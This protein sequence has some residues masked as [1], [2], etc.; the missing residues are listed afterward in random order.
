M[1]PYI[2]FE[3]N[4]VLRHHSRTFSSPPASSFRPPYVK[5]SDETNSVVASC[6]ATKPSG[7]NKLWTIVPRST[8]ARA[9]RFALYLLRL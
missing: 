9:I 3:I 8:M 1:L 5:I 4:D 2:G 7:F 6:V